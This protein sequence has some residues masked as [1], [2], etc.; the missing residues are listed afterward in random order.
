MGYEPDDLQSAEPNPTLDVELEELNARDRAQHRQDALRAL[1]D[2][3][4]ARGSAS[5]GA[6][7][8]D[9]LSAQ[10]RAVP[11]E[12]WPEGA[13]E[14]VRAVID[15]AEATPANASEITVRAVWSERGEIHVATTWDR[16]LASRLRAVPG[17][18]FSGA[19]KVWRFTGADSHPALRALLAEFEGFRVSPIASRVLHDN[20]SGGTVDLIGAGTLW[21]VSLRYSPEAVRAVRALPAASYDEET[22]AWSVPVSPD[23][24]SDLLT[25]VDRF[26]LATTS[27]AQAGLARSLAPAI[28]RH[29]RAAEAAVIRAVEQL[30]AAS[31]LGASRNLLGPSRDAVTDARATLAFLTPG[32]TKAAR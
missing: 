20:G 15:P 10:L 30:D 21:R 26:G 4:I 3:L 22:K 12:L 2:A 9:V 23:S 8:V 32:D 29:L 25:I 7:D 1:R 11:A 6:R 27:D 24:S 14:F 16:E 17:G 31:R 19:K 18:Q 5:S 28:Q 13:A